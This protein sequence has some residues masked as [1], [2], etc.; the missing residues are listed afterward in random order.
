MKICILG[1]GTAGCISA[2]TMKK[3]GHDVTIVRDSKM[4]VI[5][6][7]EATTPVFTE[8]MIEHDIDMQE[9]AKATDAMPKI[10]AGFIGWSKDIDNILLLYQDDI[11]V[12]D[13]INEY[14][15]FIRQFD[16]P[17]PYISK[18]YPCFKKSI[19]PNLGEFTGTGHYANMAWHF[20]AFKAAEFFESVA[21]KRGVDIID[22]KVVDTD[23]DTDGNLTSITLSDGTKI[24]A[25]FFIDCSGFARFLI[26]KR[27]GAEIID[28]SKSLP[29][30]H[31]I[32]LEI[33]N[34]FIDDKKF[35]RILTN[36]VA[37]DA[38]WMW[39]IPLQ[40]RWGI[41]IMYSSQ[42]SDA[43]KSIKEASELL[44]VEIEP[45]KVIKFK[46]GYLATPWVKNVVAIGLA[47]SFFEP[48]ESAST[49]YAI[50]QVRFLAGESN[51]EDFLTKQNE[52][53][54]RHRKNASGLAAFINTHYT[55]LP[56]NNDFWH[57]MRDNKMEETKGIVESNERG[58]P[59]YM[60]LDHWQFGPTTFQMMVRYLTNQPRI[61]RNST[62]MG[63]IDGWLAR[64]MGDQQDITQNHITLE[65]Y[66]EK[67]HGR[68]ENTSTTV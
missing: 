38:G 56:R 65:E 57:Y 23:K 59:G 5:G 26:Q 62:Y 2:I 4:G 40:Q 43:E 54:Q 49:Q 16:H 21:L 68:L 64:I 17:V 1:A 25:D 27:M 45:T 14:W 37:M 55:A 44:G 61:P 32:P 35:S 50:N 53:N 6:V 30:D 24:D 7:G 15:N 66:V 46:S 13:K 3:H 29:L 20:N 28:V 18:F 60:T 52:Y 47:A 39:M 31:A 67:L 9:F 34:E 8:W 10:G 33:N 51:K 42:F 22:G 63:E 19:V 48:L 36:C 41:G 11:P 12:R 58:E